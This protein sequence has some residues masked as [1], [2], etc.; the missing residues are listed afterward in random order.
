M[1]TPESPHLLGYR[2]TWR[3]GEGYHARYKTRLPHAALASGCV[4][5]VTA[6]TAWALTVAATRNRIRI[7]A[8]LTGRWA[9]VREAQERRVT[10]E[11]CPPGRHI[12]PIDV[13]PATFTKKCRRCGMTWTWPRP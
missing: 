13:Y 10:L 4:E 9:D 6:S 7:G 12:G 1:S 3:D 5:E 8:W 2:K 11:T